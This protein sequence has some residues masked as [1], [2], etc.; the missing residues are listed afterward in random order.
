MSFW[1]SVLFFTFQYLVHMLLLLSRFSRVQLC[2]TPETAAHQ[3]PPVPGILQAR[4]LECVAISFSN[5]WKWK[6]KVKSLSRVQLLAT[7]WNQAPPSMGFSRQ[8]YWSGVPLPSPWDY[9]VDLKYWKDWW[10]TWSKSSRL[11]KTTKARKLKL[12]KYFKY[13]TYPRKIT[14]TFGNRLRIDVNQRFN[15]RDSFDWLTTKVLSTLKSFWERLYL[16]T[17][18][19][20]LGQVEN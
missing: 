14:I 16:L 11:R 3:A 5:A 18:L 4:T 2:V 10:L 15:K 20:S 9:T 6:V 12:Q 1:V 7:P 19:D 17:I 8:R 13:F